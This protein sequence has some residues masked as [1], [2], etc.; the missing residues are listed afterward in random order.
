MSGLYYGGLG[1]LLAK[2]WPALGNLSQDGLS[3]QAL[4]QSCLMVVLYNEQVTDIDQVTVQCLCR[5]NVIHAYTISHAVL[6][7]ISCIHKQVEIKMD[8]GSKPLHKFT[9]LC[10]EVMWFKS[11]SANGMPKLLFDAIISIGAGP[12]Q[13]STI[14]TYQTNN[15]EAASFVCKMRHCVCVAGWFFGYWRNVM[16]YRLEMVQ[17]LMESFDMDAALLACFSKFDLVS[18]TIL[19]TFG[20]V[21]EQLESIEANLEIYQG[22]NADLEEDADTRVNVVGHQEALAMALRNHIEDV[23]DAVCSNPSC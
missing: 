17:K 5:V 21:D 16:K 14:V 13:G 10:R 9:N 8:N 23:E 19:T 15:A 2:T 20:N 4:G 18:L 12:Q 6:P 22:W 3:R 7:N 1:G 11:S